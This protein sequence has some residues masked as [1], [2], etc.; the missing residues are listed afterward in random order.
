METLTVH[1]RGGQSLVFT[2]EK[3]TVTYNATDG[4]LTK[5]KWEGEIKPE[6]L[7]WDV[8]AVDFVTVE[9]D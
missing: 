2:A 9:A 6:P 3:F 1:L 7:Y 4:T 8:D 5:M